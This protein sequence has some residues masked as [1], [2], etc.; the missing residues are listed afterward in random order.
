MIVFG[1]A[2][3]N[4]VPAVFEITNGKTFVVAKSMHCGKVFNVPVEEFVEHFWLL[5]ATPNERLCW[6]MNGGEAVEVKLSREDM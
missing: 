2:H 1:K 3:G 5:E 4:E 6:A